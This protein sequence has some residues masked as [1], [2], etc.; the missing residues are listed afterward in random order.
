MLRRA[1][2]RQKW[3]LADLRRK[4]LPYVPLVAG[5]GL[6]ASLLE[7]AGI[8]YLPTDL[9]E[10][11]IAA[12]RLTRLFADWET[13]NL[14]IHLVHPSRRVPRRVAALMQV[15]ANELRQSHPL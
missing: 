4:Y 13:A 14:P 5:L 8:A 9:V 1:G 2:G 6:L 7:G 3:P 15:L 10:D 11:D 12:G